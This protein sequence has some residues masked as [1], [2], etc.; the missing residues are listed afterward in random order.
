MLASE[1]LSP[2]VLRSAYA[3]FPS[4]VTGVCGLKGDQPIGM[5][6]SSFTSVSIDPPLASVCV[7]HTSMTWPVLRQLPRLGV[8]VLAADQG[9]IA[10]ALA[11]QCGDR[12]KDV[13]WQA[14]P[15]GCVFV[16]G[17]TLWLDCELHAEVVAG[18]HTIVVLRIVSLQPHP[19]AEPIVFYGSSFRKLAT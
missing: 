5:A 3:R 15:D 11:S 16:H 6:A 17:S 7:A 13:N 1:H 19:D 14:M 4:G 2:D 18:D 9:P 12:F 10:R 8:S